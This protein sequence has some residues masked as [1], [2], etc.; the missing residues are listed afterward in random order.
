M[1]A[2]RTEDGSCLR[3]R[4]KTLLF[5]T[6]WAG[7]QADMDARSGRWLAHHRAIPWPC[8]VEFALIGDGIKNGI[9]WPEGCHRVNLE[10]HLGRPAHLEHKGWWRS[11]C[12]S[13]SLARE[14]GCERIWHIETDAYVASSRTV[15]WLDSVKS[16]W[17][18]AW[19]PRH[20]FPET[21]L[22]AIGVD[23]FDT[24]AGFWGRYPTLRGHHPEHVLPFTRVEKGLVGDRYGESGTDPAAIDGLD[25]Y[26]QTPPNITVPY[27]GD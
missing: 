8:E 16:G 24:L 1:E 5:G 26:V 15:Q 13:A 4:V 9:S 11:F 17:E 21:C 18:V 25:F 6:A 2:R 14:L 22:Q 7:S 12:H 20:N 3:R 27:R 19:C 23:C 10:P